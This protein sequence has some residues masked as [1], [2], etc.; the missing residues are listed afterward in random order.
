MNLTTFKSDIE[1]RRQA[2][3]TLSDSLELA[4]DM[5]N[6]V[7]TVSYL[8]HPPSLDEC[9]LTSALRGY[10]EGFSER[11]KIQG[12][13]GDS[14]RLRSAAARNGGGPVSDGAGVPH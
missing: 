4:Q 12:Q 1:R 7:R 13:I 11:S 8:L 5:N 10:V 2:T 3:K 9:G 6:E 14:G